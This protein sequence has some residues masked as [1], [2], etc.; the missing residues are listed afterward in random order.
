MKWIIKIAATI[1]FLAALYCHTFVSSIKVDTI[2]ILL[3]VLCIL[4]WIFDFIKSLEISGIGKIELVKDRTGV[5]Y[6][7]AKEALEACNGSVVDAII[8]IE[9]TMEQDNSKTFGNRGAALVESIKELVKKGNV[10]RI[11]VKKA[12]GDAVVNIPVNAGLV[13]LVIAAGL[14]VL[15][16]A[17]W[18]GG[19]NC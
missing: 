19:R 4:P 12:D 9:E 2:T 5:S 17:L 13:G 8:R 1:L 11:I 14:I 7:E 15:A 3:M 6:K 16:G 10:S 18:L